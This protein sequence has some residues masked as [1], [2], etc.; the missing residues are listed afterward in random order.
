MAIAG[1]GTSGVMGWEHDRQLGG[2]VRRE[3]QRRADGYRTQ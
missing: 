2:R 3:S 1:T